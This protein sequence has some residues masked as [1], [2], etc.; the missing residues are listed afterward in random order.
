MSFPNVLFKLIHKVLVPEQHALVCNNG[1]YNVEYITPSP[2]QDAYL[3]CFQSTLDSL[4][5]NL[6]INHHCFER[7]LRVD[8]WYSNQYDCLSWA[9]YT[10]VYNHASDGYSIKIHVYFNKKLAQWSIKAKKFFDNDLSNFEVLEL[11]PGQ[12]KQIAI[13]SGKAILLLQDLL[14]EHS[15]RYM[16]ALDQLNI[17]E[18]KLSRASQNL[19]EP[20]EKATYRALALEFE[21]SLESLAIYSDSD[22]SVIWSFVCKMLDKIDQSEKSIVL[23]VSQEEPSNELDDQT[24]SH[25]EILGEEKGVQ[26]SKK[27]AE[28]ERLA[29]KFN[30]LYERMQALENELKQFLNYLQNPGCKPSKIPVFLK[31]AKKYFQDFLIVQPLVQELNDIF[32]EIMFFDP[33]FKKPVDFSKKIESIQGKID[34]IVSKRKEALKKPVFFEDF[35]NFKSV[36]FQLTK[37]EQRSIVLSVF[38]G[39]LEILNTQKSQ[40]YFVSK[41]K[42]LDFIAKQDPEFFQMLVIYL[43]QTFVFSG[44]ITASFLFFCFHKDHLKLFEKFLEYGFDPNGP[45]IPTSEDSNKYHSLLKSILMF[46]S[47][48]SKV[49][50]YV[51]LLLEYGALLNQRPILRP[52]QSVRLMDFEKLDHLSELN[53]V[54]LS[55]GSG[56]SLEFEGTLHQD[57]KHFFMRSDFLLALHRKYYLTMMEMIPQA[58]LS[59]LA[60]ALAECG[61]LEGSTTRDTITNVD[62]GGVF[63]FR[64]KQASEAYLHNL[65]A[66]PKSIVRHQSCLVIPDS[67][68]FDLCAALVLALKENADL[69]SIMNESIKFLEN[70]YARFNADCPEDLKSV[71][72]GAI[73]LLISQKT[74]FEPLNLKDIERLLVAEF[75]TA[76]IYKVRN[77]E[78]ARAVIQRMI[79]LPF[80]GL[81][82]PELKPQLL[83]LPIYGIAESRLRQ[84]EQQPTRPPQ[85]L[86][87][88]L[89]QGQPETPTST[90][91]LKK[92]RL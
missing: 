51:H 25:Q 79:Q 52:S 37:A 71:I 44:N 88:S 69:L 1:E 18:S 63:I 84:M 49:R 68:I 80:R 64:S 36:F 73:K 78:V 53:D 74:N 41:T 33:S 9:H 54:S 72:V 17:I 6:F 42:T 92:N 47:S 43:K 12:N 62:T 70:S 76:D 27:D 30:A 29:E 14:S 75:R 38:N 2:S 50:P 89:T 60:F 83:S 39:L 77:P 15:K 48:D 11:T 13:C 7:H 16:N 45:G 55:G 19:N 65:Q 31:D 91:G 90:R 58:N 82:T 40:N 59:E 21:K 28:K 57:Q 46:S 61:A 87:F 3:F 85:P 22:V 8:R 81:F 35:D 32:L 24:L 23:S 10:M 34:K 56:Y 4:E 66:T 67:E 86:V 20:E 5:T 26:L